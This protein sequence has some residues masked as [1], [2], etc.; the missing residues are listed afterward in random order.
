MFKHVP[1][2]KRTGDTAGD[3]GTDQG[4]RLLVDAALAAA[5]VVLLEMRKR[6][7]RGDWVQLVVAVVMERHVDERVIREPENDVADVVRLGSF[8]LVKHSFDSSL[9]LIRRLRR[10]HRITRY[11][12]LFSMDSPFTDAR[13]PQELKHAG[14]KGTYRVAIQFLRQE[15]SGDCTHGEAVAM[16]DALVERAEVVP[17]LF[18][19]SDIAVTLTNIGRLLGRRWRRRS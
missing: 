13:A 18:N 3:V 9:V 1:S 10:P 11:T 7:C 14:V 17:L 19:V 15:H 16:P 4:R 12:S 2:A 6:S 5:R 8:E